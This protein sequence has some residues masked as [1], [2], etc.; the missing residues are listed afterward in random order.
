MR[1]A[2]F[3]AMIIVWATTG[4]SATERIIGTQRFELQEGNWYAIDEHGERWEV[5]PGRIFVK[6]AQG[7]TPELALS[8]P[9][10]SALSL[11]RQLPVSSFYRFRF[12]SESNPIDVLAGAVSSPFVEAAFLDTYVRFLGDAYYDELWHLD[13]IRAPLGWTVTTGSSDVTIAILDDGFEYKHED[14]AANVWSNPNEIPRDGIDNDADSLWYGSPLPDDTLGWNFVDLDNDPSADRPIPNRPNPSHGTAV[15]GMASATKDNDVGVAGVAGGSPS[16]R[17]RF[18]PIR[19]SVVGEVVD[20]VEYCWRKGFDV[21]AMSWTTNDPYGLVHAVLD[22]AYAHGAVLVASSGNSPA[23][24][25]FPPASYSSLI[26]VGGV[27]PGGQQLDYS[28]GPEQE[29]VAPTRM[30]SSSFQLWT[31]DNYASL[32]SYN[33]EVYCA[34]PADNPNYVSHFNGT[35]AACPQVAA[36]AALVKSHW[37]SMSNVDIRQRL[38]LSAIDIGDVGW[39]E[40]FGYGRVDVYRALTEWGTITGNV[41]WSPSDTHDGVR[42]VSGD[43]TIASGDTLTIMPGTIVRIANDD[44]LRAGAD[45]L[46]VEINVEGTLIAEGTSAD[47]IV[48]ESWHPTTTEDWVGIYFD[49]TSGG[50][51]LDNCAISGADVGILSY[52]DSLTLTNSVIDSCGVGVQQEA[53]EA[54]IRDCQFTNGNGGVE[55]RGGEMTIRNTTV[56]GAVNNAVAVYAPAVLDIRSSVFMNSEVGLFVSGD[57]VVDVDSSCFFYQ[58]DT[59]IHF[60]DAGTASTIKSSGITWNASGGILCDAS[61]A[62]D[63]VS[64]IFAHNGGAIYC[65]NSSSPTIEANQIQ[66]GG[67]A[68]T[69]A[70]SS[71]PDVGHSPATGSQSQ[72]YNKIAHA[73]KYISNSTGAS[74]SAQNN[75]WNVNGGGCSPSASK[76]VGTVNYTNPIC[77][78][79]ASFSHNEGEPEFE[80]GFVFQLPVAAP[81]EPRKTYVTGLTSIVPN[82]FNPTTTISY[83]LSAQGKVDIKIYDVAGR[84]VQELANGMQTA[85]PHSAVW[86]GT[87]RRGTQVAS[88]VYFVRMV[89]AGQVFTKKMVMLK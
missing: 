63:I 70:S 68:I 69:A 74:I 85:G 18:V 21:I 16:E 47:T 78:T 6:F 38:Q 26:A 13:E 41:T 46:R 43:L 89:A 54:L 37:L 7:A 52:A 72:G 35:S 49:I 40:R 2:L 82:P 62:P 42:Y 23:R 88:G 33:P 84:L 24:L 44:D 64:N 36:V 19:M 8:S 53:G 61:S 79:F 10:F 87:D 76:F 58:N 86:T 39:D 11:E 27:G 12:S 71:S 59:G 25:V 45:T 66:S 50:G 81:S 5:A 14:L 30:S 31:T 65:S 17:P 51:T 34:C 28:W 3:V 57:A 22:S 60:Y 32:T 48:F 83:G 29:L 73:V 75:C 80:E 9:S 1:F 77:C 4:S 15:A 67:N 55:L 56:D 20:A